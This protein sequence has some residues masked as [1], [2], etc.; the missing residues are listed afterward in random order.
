MHSLIAKPRMQDELTDRSSRF[1]QEEVEVYQITGLG[2]HVRISESTVVD[3][4]KL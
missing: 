2:I 4:E 3:I 1:L